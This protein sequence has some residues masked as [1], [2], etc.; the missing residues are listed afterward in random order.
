[1]G[2]R[3]FFEA[4]VELSLSDADNLPSFVCAVQNSVRLAERRGVVNF[5]DDSRLLLHTG[6]GDKLEHGG[7]P[8]G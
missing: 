1:L 6:L 3:K 2:S 8:E 7:I 5:R 4:G